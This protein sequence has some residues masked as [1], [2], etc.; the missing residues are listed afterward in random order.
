MNIF[1]KITEYTP[2]I[3]KNHKLYKKISKKRM[4]QNKY[5]NR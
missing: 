2:N 4:Q 1:K 3:R 5:L